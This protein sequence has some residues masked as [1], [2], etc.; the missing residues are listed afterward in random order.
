MIDLIL[1]TTDAGVAAQTVIVLVL[2]AGAVFATRRR[3]EWM[4]LAIGVTM[5]IL[6]FFGVRALH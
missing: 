5:V 3:K 4:L 2:G 1:P 6:G